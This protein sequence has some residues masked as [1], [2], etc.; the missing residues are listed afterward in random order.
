MKKGK[1]KNKKK[2]E[3]SFFVTSSSSSDAKEKASA[4]ARKKWKATKNPL[5]EEERYLGMRSRM[6]LL[7]SAFSRSH[8]LSQGS[9]HWQLHNPEAGA[10]CITSSHED[11]GHASK[12]GAFSLPLPRT[13]NPCASPGLSGAAAGPGVELRPVPGADRLRGC[14]THSGPYDGPMTS[15]SSRP[16]RPSHSLGARAS[17]SLG[18]LARRRFGEGRIVRFAFRWPPMPSGDLQNHPPGPAGAGE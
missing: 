16:V 4:K 15:S 17:N 2:E 9:K 12:G 11:E 3:S 14:H 10:P 8:S 5:V 18:A 13:S 1:P 7:T 6:T